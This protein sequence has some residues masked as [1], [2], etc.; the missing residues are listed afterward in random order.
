VRRWSARTRLSAFAAGLVAVFALGYG[1]GALG[2][3][4]DPAPTPSTAPT[5]TVAMHQHGHVFG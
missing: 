2:A 4:D 5:T 3:P 1:V